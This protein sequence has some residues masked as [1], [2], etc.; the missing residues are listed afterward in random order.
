MS[1]ERRAF[2]L[3]VLRRLRESGYASLWAGGCVRDLLLGTTPSDYDVATD[4]RPDDVMRIFPRRTLPLGAEFGV[5]RVL[6]P[7]H[8]GLEVEVA[9]FRGDGDYHDGRRPSSIAYSTPEVDAERR[10]FT[11]NGMFFDPLT[12][13]V[14]DYVGGRADLDRRVLRAIG[15]PAARFNEDKLRLVR[16]ARFAA[17]FGLA[18]DPSTRA[19]IIDFAPRADQVAA[20][21]I[22]VELRKMLAHRTRADAVELLLDLHLARVILPPIV[23]LKGVFQGKPM[24]PEGD[25]WAHTML[26]LRLLPDDAPFPLAFASLLH[27]VG[28]PTTMAYQRLRTTFYHHE[29]VGAR[30]ADALCRALKLST[31]ER[32]RVTWLVE[33]HQYLA[34]ALRMRESKL[35]RMLASPD[36]DDLLTLHRAD[37][38]ASFGEAPHVDYCE[39]YRR[40]EP[41]GPINPPPLVTG[42]DLVRHGLRPGPRFAEYLEAIR[43]AQLD[44]LLHGKQ[45]ALDWLDRKIAEE[46]ASSSE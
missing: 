42:H 12:D 43:E 14:I 37:A 4:A 44:G 3:D 2:A 7:T 41:S 28:K 6:G 17:R 9:S 20:E 34:D 36:I 16:A 19:A 23:A 32:A 11:I 26:V 25:L 30:S 10:D 31:A 18:V 27:D 35:K 39:E 5:V 29:Q 24:Q 15:D 13:T 38:L 46:S 21:R 22:A 33:H 40:S 1:D 45:E 8:S